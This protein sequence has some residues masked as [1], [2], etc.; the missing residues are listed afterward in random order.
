VTD[1]VWIIVIGSY[2]WL[3]YIAQF[4]LLTL[5]TLM[6]AFGRRSS[7]LTPATAGLGLVMAANLLDLLPNATQ[8]PF[9]WLMAGALLGEAERLAL[10]RR[11]ADPEVRRDPNN[12]AKPLRTVI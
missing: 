5:P 8:I 10:A 7:A 11:A 2:G 6:L 4:G 12:A 1:G 9:T 3:G